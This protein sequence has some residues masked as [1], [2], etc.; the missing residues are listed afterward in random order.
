MLLH[1]YIWDGEEQG[2]Y[3]AREIV[4]ANTGAKSDA[5]VICYLLKD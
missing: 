4:E 2:M 1:D 3:Y 5:V